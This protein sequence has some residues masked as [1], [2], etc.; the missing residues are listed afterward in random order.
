VLG[1]YIGER[2][3]VHQRATPEDR[4][5][6][7]HGVSL[8]QRTQRQSLVISGCKSDRLPQRPADWLSICRDERGVAE[9]K[10]IAALLE[11]ALQLLKLPGHP[12]IVLIGERN[13]V[14]FAQLNRLLEV[15]DG[16]KPRPIDGDADRHSRCAGEVFCDFEG[17][18]AGAVVGDDHLVRRARL[19][20]DRLQLLP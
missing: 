19:A 14:A 10:L 7:R 20:E 3:G 12:F 4:C 17:A 8:P 2:H 1:H 11:S 5:G 15:A 6:A 18:I 13:E 9:Y 16:A